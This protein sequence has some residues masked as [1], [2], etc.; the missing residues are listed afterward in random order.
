MQHAPAAMGLGHE[1]RAAF[2][3]SRTRRPRGLVI[4][5]PPPDEIGA[6]VD[7]S[8]WY[9]TDEEDM[10]HAPE[11]NEASRIFLTSLVELAR[12][13]GW[14]YDRV[15]ADEFFAWVPSEPQVRVSPDVFVTPDAPPP[16]FP[17]S[18]QTWTPGHHAPRFALEIVSEDW[19]KDY[20]DNPPKY[21][22]LGV[23]ELAIFDPSAPGKS[24]R[25]LLQVYRR[26]ADGSFVRVHS[27]GGPVRSEEL[28]VWLVV[29]GEGPSARLRLAR[30]AAGADLV[31]TESEARQ[32]AEQAR[33]AAEQARLAAEQAQGAAER[34]RADAE[35]GRNEAER[36]LAR[37]RDELA[38]LR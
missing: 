26:D 2:V 3:P 11:H 10:A 12:E 36:E 38:R 35:Q 9:L 29:Q 25:F 24:E 16:P 32:A 13:R 5:N 4:P 23:R 21:A 31:P 22:Q 17:R 8:P 30:D 19:K 27:G 34:A 14:Q 6:E 33:G 7:W 1:G 28:G 15:A 20:D 37:L 18:W